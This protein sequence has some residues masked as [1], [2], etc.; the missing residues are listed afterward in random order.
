VRNVWPFLGDGLA[1]LTERADVDAQSLQSKRDLPS[2]SVLQF[3]EIVQRGQSLGKVHQRELG[4]EAFLNK[5]RDKG[6]WE[7]EWLRRQIGNLLQETI[8]EV[9]GGSSNSGILLFGRMAAAQR[10]VLGEK[11]ARVHGRQWNLVR[12]WVGE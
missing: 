4:S 3:L 2:P 1:L 5:R 11:V 8:L 9:F 6:G 12:A 10:L 7:G